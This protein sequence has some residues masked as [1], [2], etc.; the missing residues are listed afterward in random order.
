MLKCMA[1]NSRYSQKCE[2]CGSSKFVEDHAA[3]DLICQLPSGSCLA[4][5]GRGHSRSLGQVADGSN[6]ASAGARTGC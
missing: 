6:I 3:G 2:D 4:D 5:F 1:D